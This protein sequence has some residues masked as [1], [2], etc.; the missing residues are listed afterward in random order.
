MCLINA[1]L[2]CTVQKSQLLTNFSL[3]VKILILHLRSGH[4]EEKTLLYYA[5]S[6]ILLF[7]PII[8]TF[9]EKNGTSALLE[10]RQLFSVEGREAATVAFTD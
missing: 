4:W 10:N 2:Y 5:C 7:A 8:C 1:R 3:I 6:A 9:Q